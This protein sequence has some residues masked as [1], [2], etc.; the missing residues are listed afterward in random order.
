MNGE[1]EATADA[2]AGKS[3]EPRQRSTIGFPYMDLA[4]SIE[5]AQAIFKNVAAGECDDDQLAAWTN[6]SSKSSGFRV[7]VYAARTFGILAGEA[8]RHSLT[9]LGLS[10]I[11]SLREREARIKAFLHVPLYA[12]VFERFKGG[13]LPPAAALEREMVALGVAPKQ[14][15]R[16]RQV[17]ERSAEQAGFFAHGKDRL[18]QPGVAPGQHQPPKDEKPGGGG[19]GGNGGNGGDGVAI[20]PIIQ[21][22]LAR[23]PKSGETWPEA[24]R[25]LWLNLLE[26]SFGLIYKDGGQSH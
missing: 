12:A 13:A 21:G 16:A 17:F 10:V 14:K 26:G 18:I 5:L 20:D 11:D 23:L 7:Q 4:S 15:D 25:K 6:Q 24:Q 9:D 1:S 2:A 3:S 19:N 8:S 22:L